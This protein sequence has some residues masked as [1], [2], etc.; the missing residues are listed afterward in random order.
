MTL[1]FTYLGEIDYV[2]SKGDKPMNIHWR[3]HHPVPQDLFI[4]LIK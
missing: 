1:P 2:S 3:L 4:D